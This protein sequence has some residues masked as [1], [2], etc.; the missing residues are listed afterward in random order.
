M[1]QDTASQSLISTLKG[2]QI[3]ASE[4]ESIVDKFNEV[5]NNYAIDTA[6]IGEA[7]QR[8][9]SAFNASHT[10][11]DKAIALV[12]TTNSVLQS[13]EAVG[14]LWNT[15]SAR[16]RGA[17]IELSD[18]NEE[19]DEYTQSTSKLRDMVKGLTGFD[20][21]EADGSTF[22]DIYD[23]VVGIA[24]KWDSLSDIDQAGLAEALAGKRNSK[25]LFAV[26]ANIDDLKSAYE[27]SITSAGSAAREQA[28]Y[29]ESVQYSIDRAKASLQELATDFL[30]SSTL[31]GMIEFGNSAIKILDKIVDKIG[32]LGTAIAGLGIKS[33]VQGMAD[34]NH[35]S[36]VGKLFQ[37]IIGS[38]QQ[39]RLNLKD[40]SAT[41]VLQA[42][43]TNQRGIGD[44]LKGFSSAQAAATAIGQMGGMSD[45]N[46]VKAIAYAW[47]DI[48]E[49]VVAAAKGVK[50]VDGQM[51]KA[52][53]SAT[54]LKNIAAGIAANWKIIV[55]AAIV[56]I[57]LVIHKQ[58]EKQKA[59]LRQQ[60]YDAANA[61]SESLNT[62]QNQTASVQE[63]RQKLDSGT[64]SDEE[65]VNIKQQIY[66]IQKQIVDQ[67]GAQASAID[68]VNGNL[69]AQLELLDAISVVEAEKYLRDNQSAFTQAENDASVYYPDNIF[70]STHGV[71]RLNSLFESGDFLTET[72]G[73]VNATRDVQNAIKGA[74]S[75]FGFKMYGNEGQMFLAAG[76]V[77][78]QEAI[79]AYIDTLQTLKD[80]HKDDEKYVAQIDQYIER[81]NAI[82]QANGAGWQKTI[83]TLQTKQEMELVAAGGGSVISQYKTATT[84]YQTALLTGETDKVREARSEY[85]LATEA[86]NRF[87][88]TSGLDESDYQDMLG[89]IDQNLD[90][91]GI[92]L[93]D[94]QEVLGTIN[95]EAA[96]IDKN[97]KL[98]GK[99]S[100][101][102]Q[103]AK[104]IKKLQLDRVDISK[105]LNSKQLDSASQSIRNKIKYLAATVGLDLTDMANVS[106]TE[107]SR[108]LDALVRSGV[109]LG[110]ATDA[111]KASSQ[112]Y[113][114]LK[115]T[116]DAA[117]ESLTT[118]NTSIGE[119]RNGA[120]IT[121]DNVDALKKVF[122]KD[123]AHA[124]ERTANGFH[125]NAT[126][127]EELRDK[128]NELV[129]TDYLST[130]SEQY[131]ELEHATAEYQE[132]LQ[133]G[134]I[135]D[136]ASWA[137][138]ISSIE[139]TIAK[140]KDL[141]VQYDA[142]TSAYQNY[143][144]ASG[145]EKERSMYEKIYAG[146]ENT[147]KLIEVQGWH[148][149]PEV[150]TWLELV[151]G[152]SR[153]Q[154]D[155]QEEI[156]ESFN[157]LTKKIEGT[158]FSVKDFFTPIDEEN[159]ELT[160][161][162][163]FN[164]FDAII[165]KQ[166]EVGKEFVKLDKGEYS[167]DFGE[168]GDYQVAKLLGLNVET[169]QAI[170]RA[171]RDAGFS[172]L[173]IDEPLDQIGEL[174]YEANEARKALT[175][176][177]DHRITSLPMTEYQ[178]FETITKSI[179]EIQE[180]IKEIE[181]SDEIDFDVRYEKLQNANKMLDYLVAL[182][183]K[184]AENHSPIINVE[185]IDNEIK[186]YEKRLDELRKEDGTLDFDVEATEDTL[187]VLEMLYLLQQMANEPPVMKLDVSMMDASIG[188]AVKKV[189]D[190][191]LA[192][193]NLN[194]QK[195]LLA[196]GAD[197]DLSG[198][199]EAV[200]SLAFD[201]SNIDPEILATLSFD[202]EQVKQ[203]ATNVAISANLSD[204]TLGELTSQIQAMDVGQIEV[205]AVVKKTQ[206]VKDLGQALEDLPDKV[207]SIITINGLTNAISRMEYLL[208]LLDRFK[209]YK[210]AQKVGAT[211]GEIYHMELGAADGTAHS[212]G[213]WG[214]K[215]NEDGSLVNEL[216]P[217]IIVRDG[218][219]F[220]VNGGH[221]AITDFKRGD[222]IF[223]HK[224]SEEI[225]K[226]GYV[227]SGHGKMI[228]RANGSAFS[229][230]SSAHR[231]TYKA[232][233]SSSSRSGSGSGS[234]AADKA[235]EE[236][237]DWVEVLLQRIARIFDNFK[238]MAE[239]WA[240]YNNQ[241]KELNSA[242]AQ[243]RTNIVKNEQAYKR[244]ME[245]TQYVGL[246]ETY[247][248]KVRNGE[249]DIEAIT[250]EDLK[251]KIEKYTEW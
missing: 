243:A 95:D 184:A 117:I 84:N 142:A 53:N 20:I 18:L 1:T 141:A 151:T 71:Y 216:G 91:Y 44:A 116:V 49:N 89:S 201:I 230:G 187:K 75:D 27:T 204:E 46:K 233:S 54:K 70:E 226:H 80:A 196:Q 186:T 180:Y 96:E 148:T 228:G 23:I 247:A 67:Y 144:N 130:L 164:F 174:R 154:L 31:K 200:Q 110:D 153:E 185:D 26:L 90:T 198:A 181:N 156:E 113:T 93:F 211:D 45:E 137:R 9:A 160:S 190:F 206:D 150:V 157:S 119:S 173:H 14:T 240:T 124:L 242:I 74:L 104:D 178:D 92:K 175:A 161:G 239:Y 21:V 249:L 229:S 143:I 101:V 132:A 73:G 234:N 61:W 147:E 24:D 63:L 57:G 138:S 134:R 5:A 225:I 140:V 58:I 218:Q 227:T 47:G 55:P 8:S 136:A 221:P 52:G 152:K 86:K 237:K 139:N 188:E 98:I 77:D 135:D 112:S 22:K 42:A 35:G 82:V 209:N 244:Y 12:T 121:A 10:E 179:G 41:K 59:E 210:G 43:M 195:A 207:N 182:Q 33:A 120:G 106:E 94:L 79:N 36:L 51:G 199:I 16:I 103:L 170:I 203:A 105:I 202:P 220:T 217:E 17:K 40:S 191:Y 245:E 177:G 69:R 100:V 128:Q 214:L 81:A 165:E 15:M 50:V 66:D 193:E 222:I 213:T 223:N 212:G 97:N 172:E 11:L 208:Q 2:F 38:G 32:L 48:D 127:A 115:T 236:I 219:W 64:L 3:D 167:F 88:M 25:G 235:Q 183:G 60:A 215:K 39:F 248:A 189:Q 131:K 149:D 111:T 146:F 162:G 13:P 224:Q 171:A 246:S 155:T 192:Y 28:H 6:G 232:T 107:M 99:N 78:A 102:P 238:N 122:G 250:D 251:L 126:A 114:Q 76:D 241:L 168:H 163:I 4:A 83:E 109:I 72:L 37:A 34:P 129:K 65:T 194:A 231:P 118:F 133:A 169:V 145:A 7:L 29:A 197:V 19:E 68:L 108:F 158:S 56:G 123:L 166:K 205:E 62:I 159:K 125:L 176:M 30:K 85:L 87:F